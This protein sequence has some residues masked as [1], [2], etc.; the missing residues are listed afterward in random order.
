MVVAA[1][2][3]PRRQGRTIAQAILGEG[4]GMVM[5]RRTVTFRGTVQGVGFRWTALR[6][7]G[8]CAVTGTVRNAF[9]GSVELVAEGELPEVA[10]LVAAIAERMS[11]YLRE[12]TWADGPATGEYRDFRVIR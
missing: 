10:A 8:G 7:A 3:A 2:T 11:G 6:L 9:D 12:T 4:Q 5:I 1:D